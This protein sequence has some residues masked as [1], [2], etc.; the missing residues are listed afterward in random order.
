[1]VLIAKVDKK[2][3][4]TKQIP[5]KVDQGEPTPI[6]Q[7]RPTNLFIDLQEIPLVFQSLLCAL[8]LSSQH[9]VDAAYGRLHGRRRALRH[10]LF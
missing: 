2:N 4:L 8:L 7:L 10:R 1:M 9:N 3:E 5:Q 6:F